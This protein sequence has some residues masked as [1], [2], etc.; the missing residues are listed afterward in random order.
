MKKGRKGLLTL[1]LI[2]VIFFQINKTI[3]NKNN[4]LINVHVGLAKELFLF[5]PKQFHRAGWVFSSAR[6]F[7]STR[8]SGDYMSLWFACKRK[9]ALTLLFQENKSSYVTNVW[10]YT[11]ATQLKL[12]KTEAYIQKQRAGQQYYYQQMYVPL[13]SSRFIGTAFYQLLV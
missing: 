12:N 7:S 1:L 4:F 13:I 2:Q 9:P 11:G 6:Q 8:Q 10:P 3:I 5:N